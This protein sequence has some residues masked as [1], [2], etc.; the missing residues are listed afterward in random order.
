MLPTTQPASSEQESV[1]TQTSDNRAPVDGE[2]KDKLGATA[3]KD[4]TGPASLWPK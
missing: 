2:L 4:A 3:E 1:M